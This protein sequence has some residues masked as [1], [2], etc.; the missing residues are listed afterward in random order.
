MRVTGQHGGRVAATKGTNMTWISHL[1]RYAVVALVV[2]TV[3]TG[4]AKTAAEE[5]ATTGAAT[6]QP[7]AGGDLNRVTLT[8][9]AV[10]RLD[11]QTGEVVASQAGLTVPYR[12]VFYDAQGDTWVFVS[13]RPRT[14]VRAPVTVDHIDGDLAYLAEGPQVG[15]AVVTV[16][17]PEI[18]GAEVGVGDDE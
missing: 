18:Y 14:F 15:T 7:V 3:A 10:K 16:G 4:C 2:G 8:A 6:V 12:A 5:E 11:V 17:G 13:P 1:R 9:A